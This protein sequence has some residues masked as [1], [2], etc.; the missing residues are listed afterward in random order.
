MV[1]DTMREYIRKLECASEG[2]YT[3]TRPAKTPLGLGSIEIRVQNLV[4]YPLLNVRPTKAVL[5]DPPAD[6]NIGKETVILE[7]GS[8][9]FCILLLPYY[10]T[11][12]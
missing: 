7:Q 6:C 9:S 1:P 11:V 8:G 5:L 10:K 3:W 12:D 2:D 4:P